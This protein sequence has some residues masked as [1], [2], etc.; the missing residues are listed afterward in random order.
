MAKGTSKNRTPSGAPS[1]AAREKY[2][3]KNTGEFPIFDKQSADAAVDLRG[4][5]NS[6]LEEEWILRQ[7]GKYDPA[8]T[9]RAREADRKKK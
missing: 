5:A 9:K 6:K 7:A 4:Q 1:A 8:A 2:G 3:Y